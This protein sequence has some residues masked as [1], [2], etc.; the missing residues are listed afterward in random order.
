MKPRQFSW[1]WLLLGLVALPVAA[2]AVLQP[3]IG[4]TPELRDRVAAALSAWTGATITLTEPLSM[5]YFPPLSLRGG[6]VLTNATKF[7]LVKSITAREVKITLSLPDLLMGRM[8]IDALRLSRPKITLKDTVDTVT[9][10][11]QTLEAL[12]TNA[13]VG[14][15]VGFVRIGNGTIGT[16]SGKRLAST[17]NARLDASEGDGTLSVLGS[18]DLRGE[19]V[20]FA[21]DS[22]AISKIDGHA[23]APTTLRITSDP[24]T[25]KLSGTVRLGER[26]ELDG[27]MQAEMPSVRG[28][29]N[30]T[31][32]TVPKGQSLQGLSAAGT[33]HW[34]G[35]TLTIENGSFTLD[36][37]AA[38]GLLAITTGERPRVEG[39]L[40]FEQ[41]VLDPY[42]SPDDEQTMPANG[43]LFEWALLKYF[44]ADLRIS[45]AEVRASTMKLGRGGL[46][47]TAKDGS[48]SS[49]VGELELCGGQAAGRAGFDLSGA[50]IKATLTGDLSHVAVETCLQPLGLGLPIKGLSHLKIDVST[51]GRT[52][53]DLIRGLAGEFKLKAR[54]GAVPVDFPQLTTEGDDAGSAGWSQERVTSFESL[55]AD[56]RLSA[57]HIWC[58]SF[59]MQT[60]QGPISGSGGVDLGRQTLDWDF[61]IANP[62]APLDA[63]QLVMEIPPRLTIRG[64]LAQPLIQRANRPTLGDRSKQISPG[65]ARVSPR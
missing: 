38:D 51:G 7:P 49:E 23:V 58:Q 63:S 42:V 24:V 2:L 60:L 39:T 56:C 27:K 50:R 29:L 34:S 25:A 21:I 4:T 9:L 1:K 62:V 37:N 48:I 32:V 55:D 57:G 36:G 61:L 12:I 40:A 18:V 16:A 11:E 35:S 44:D 41:L 10:P 47:I 43:A 14:A 20:R 53:E 22:G 46:T 15:P 33:M 13:L 54:N 6:F 28:F 30:W 59:N 64:S 3:Q 5:Q 45:A 52:W 19:L 17:L 8:K 26:L 31:G 65:S